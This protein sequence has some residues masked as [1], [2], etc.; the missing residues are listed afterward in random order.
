MG[1][2]LRMEMRANKCTTG[3]LKKAGKALQA[4]CWPRLAARDGG[5]YCL[6]LAAGVADELDGGC[7]RLS[8]CGREPGVD[9]AM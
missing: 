8:S 1:I 7:A 2:H 4:L 9:G 3:A 6:F 5:G